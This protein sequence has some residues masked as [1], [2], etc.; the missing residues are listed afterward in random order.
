MKRVL[1]ILIA[2]KVNYFEYK[3][4][5]RVITIIRKFEYK[6]FFFLIHLGN[7]NSDNE[8]RECDIKTNIMKS[9]ICQ[10]YNLNNSI[11]V[12]YFL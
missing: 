1:G 6:S 5:K 4:N 2:M 11:Y 9:N 7:E 8:S 3:S 10:K 12:Q